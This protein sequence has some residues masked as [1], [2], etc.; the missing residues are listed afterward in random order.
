MGVYEKWL[1]MD[2]RMFLIDKY[3]GGKNGLDLG[4]YEHKLT[5]D[6]AKG[7]DIKKNKNVQIAHDLNKSFTFVKSCS[8]DFIFAGEIIEHLKS[9]DFFL[10]E[11]NRVLKKNGFMVLT[12]WNSRSLFASNESGHLNCFMKYQ[13]ENRMK[14]YFQIVESGYINIF[15]RN[16][17]KKLICHLKPDWRWFIYVVGKKR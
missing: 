3:C 10:K 13:I 9:P 15:K 1:K 6:N 5:C 12:T 4:S 2:S 16:I 17:I 8:Q 11:C 7:V 14:E